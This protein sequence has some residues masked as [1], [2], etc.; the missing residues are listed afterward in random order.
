MLM[1]RSPS[2]V[3]WA[4]KKRIGVNTD[5][6]ACKQCMQPLRDQRRRHT[7]VYVRLH[8][9]IRI[10]NMTSITG[11]MLNGRTW[12]LPPVHSL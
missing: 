6:P 2:G 9:H 3:R 8:G 4:L 12:L 11:A 5:E 1:F 10:V 7:C